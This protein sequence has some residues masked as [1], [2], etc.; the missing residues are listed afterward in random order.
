MQSSTSKSSNERKRPWYK[1]KVI[2]IFMLVLS[3]FNWIFVDAY[4]TGQMEIKPT[5]LVL[6]RDGCDFLRQNGITPE[7]QSSMDSCRV[8]I[9]F[10]ANVLGLGGR[11]FI[12]DR[13][14]LIAESQI[15]IIAALDDQ[16]WSPSQQRLMIWL[17]V[18]TAFII[19][20]AAW[21]YLLFYEK[22]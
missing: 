1:S 16:S 11:A 20:M 10:R 5:M 6:K 12:G 14:I 4:I 3:I 19:A 22:D 13:H 2:A 8:T 17:G 15:S 7:A 18:C 21:V 9:P